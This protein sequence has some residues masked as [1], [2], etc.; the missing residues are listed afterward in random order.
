MTI[1]NHKLRVQVIRIALIVPLAIA[2]SIAVRADNLSAIKNPHLSSILQNLQELA[3]DSSAPGPYQV[4]IFDVPESDDECEGPISSCPN[5]Y[6]YIVVSD[7]GL[8]N[9]ATLYEMPVAKGWKFDGW[10]NGTKVAGKE[11]LEGFKIETSIPDANIDSAE[12]KKW[13]PTVYEVWI[14]PR[15]AQFS[16][17]HK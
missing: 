6:L 11:D 3:T 17:V 2:S 13:Q 14:S 16:I 8:G 4:R 7:D 12:Y 15:Q 1:T 5:E 10:M 9:P